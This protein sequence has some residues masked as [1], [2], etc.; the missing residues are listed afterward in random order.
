MRRI[1]V[2]QD[3]SLWIDLNRHL[4]GV[5]SVDL[6]E[7]MSFEQARILAQVERP[8][9]VVYRAD[10]SGPAPEELLRQLQ[11][12]GVEK[13]VVIAVERSSG[14]GPPSDRS[15]TA[16]YSRAIVCTP[17]ELLDQVS[18][19]LN[20]DAAHAK[21]TVE[22]LAHYDVNAGS[23]E[24]PRSGFAVVLELTERRLL[25]EADLSLEPGAEM[26]LNFFLQEPGS[27]AQRS[28]VSL[29]CAVTQCHDEAK[30]VYSVRITKLEDKS[31]DAIQRYTASCAGG[32]AR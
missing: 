16:R 24:E 25:L 13:S 4:S 7:A 21:P 10:G 29:A 18:R 8:E 28:N 20:L 1:L 15:D 30:L 27:D 5:E 3:V 14:A 11:E 19:L 6:V 2:I 31:R 22:L 26:L 12:R 32:A 17:E 23:S 9:I